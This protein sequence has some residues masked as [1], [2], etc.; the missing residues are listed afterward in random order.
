MR[1]KFWPISSALT[2]S[3][4]RI[5]KL[6]MP[7]VQRGKASGVSGVREGGAAQAPCAR[8]LGSKTMVGPT[9]ENEVL[10]RLRA[11]RHRVDE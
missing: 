4:E 11:G 7:A 5:S 9:W 8:G 10:E 1:K 3:A 2:G 6:P